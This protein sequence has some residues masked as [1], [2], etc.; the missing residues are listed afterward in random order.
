MLQGLKCVLRLDR[1]GG[2]AASGSDSKRFWSAGSVVLKSVK[3]CTEYY[4]AK[5]YNPHRQT[6]KKK[7]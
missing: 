7:K 5:T 3:N 2:A 4:T 6:F 1:I